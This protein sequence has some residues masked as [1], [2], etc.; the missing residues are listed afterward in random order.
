[1]NDSTTLPSQTEESRRIT[2]AEAYALLEAGRAV[3]LDVREPAAFETLHARAAI[4]VPHV[5]V[6]ASGGRFPAG[7]SAPGDSLLILYC[8]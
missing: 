7:V 2:A 3:L 1:M 5:A 8:G 4:S 6:Q